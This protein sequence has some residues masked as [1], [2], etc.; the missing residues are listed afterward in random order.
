MNNKNYEIL[1][2]NDCMGQFHNDLVEQY[3][4]LALKNH[5]CGS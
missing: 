5:W 3:M 2:F 1:Y 4:F